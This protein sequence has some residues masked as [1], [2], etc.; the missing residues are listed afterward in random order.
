MLTVGQDPRVHPPVGRTAAEERLRPGARAR[1]VLRPATR[2]GRSTPSCRL[3]V[4]LVAP[5]TLLQ[6]S[7]HP[8]SDSDRRISIPRVQEE[9]EQMDAD[10][11]AHGNCGTILAVVI[12]HHQANCRH[13]PCRHHSKGK[14]RRHLKG[15]MKQPNRRLQKSLP[16]HE[17]RWKRKEGLLKH[18]AGSR[19]D[20]DIGSR[21]GAGVRHLTPSGKEAA[22]S[23][24]V[25]GLESRD[26]LTSDAVK[27]KQYC[28]NDWLAKRCLQR[29]SLC[30]STQ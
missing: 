12:T 10:R 20:A 19:E 1:A 24:I 5:L 6:F 29:Q 28:Q 14:L 9:R 18:R 27:G 16:K 30:I 13:D 15:I 22:R 21:L 2:R 3:L 23:D 8:L 17:G 11:G 7:C 25:K 26:N 4:S